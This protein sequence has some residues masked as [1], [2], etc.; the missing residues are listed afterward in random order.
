[1]ERLGFTGKIYNDMHHSVPPLNQDSILQGMEETDFSMKKMRQMVRLLILYYQQIPLRTKRRQ[2]SMILSQIKQTYS[3]LTPRRGA[4]W[5]RPEGG[6][7]LGVEDWLGACAALM[8]LQP[9]N[10]W[11]SHSMHWPLQ[12]SRHRAVPYA[13]TFLGIFTS[14]EVHK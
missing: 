8:V 4:Y 12:I 6:N 1:M 14:L 11:R 9:T 5:I 10:F 7:Q 3:L 13:C 2:I